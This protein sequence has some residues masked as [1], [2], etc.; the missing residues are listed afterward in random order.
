MVYDTGIN[1]S[2][3]NISWSEGAPYGEELPAGGYDERANGLCVAENSL[4]TMEDS[5]ELVNGEV[6][7]VSE[8]GSRCGKVRSRKSEAS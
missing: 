8:Y 4:I 7:L 1:A 3:D 6:M 5:V 2:F